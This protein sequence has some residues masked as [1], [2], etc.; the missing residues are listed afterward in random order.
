[1]KTL[2]KIRGL[3]RRSLPKLSGFIRA[4]FLWLPGRRKGIALENALALDFEGG[5]SFYADTTLAFPV[6]SKYL[7]YKRT[8]TTTFYN[9]VNLTDGGSGIGSFPLGVSPDAPFQLND[10]VTIFRLGAR[11]GMML[12]LTGTTIT[13]DHLVVAGNNGLLVDATTIANGTY[14]VV[15]RATA[16]VTPGSANLSCAFIPVFPYLI[17]NTGGT[18][19]NPTNPL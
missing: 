15:G 2:E 8:N 6:T 17:T 14:W 16:T 12:G 1:M 5:E 18:L 11:K 4:P 9:T 3:R 10:E 7:L 13:I 19:T